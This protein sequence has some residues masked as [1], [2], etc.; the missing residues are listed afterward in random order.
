MVTR[1]HGNGE[2][3]VTTGRSY[4]ASDGLRI[5]PQERIVF[6][7]DL[8]C[9]G[10]FRCEADDP[11]FPHC[12]PPSVHTFVFPR[13]SVRIRHEGSRAFTA[14]PNTVTFYNRGQMYSRAKVSAEGDKCD[15]YTV[16]PSALRAIAAEVDPQAADTPEKPFR[17]SHGPSDNA[18]YLE[19]RRV[20]NHA[21]SS[22]HP[23]VLFVEET[24]LSVLS[25]V[26]EQTHTAHAGS[27]PGVRA[28]HKR[29]DDGAIEAVQ[30]RIARDFHR[31][32]SLSTLAEIAGLSVFHLC[33]L[34]RSEIGVTIHRYRHQLRLRQAL[35]TLTDSSTD[36]TELALDL[37]YSSHSHFTYVFRKTF[38][39]SPA[40]FRR[41]ASVR[42][43]RSLK[44]R[45]GW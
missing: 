23:D 36:L 30:L 24:I 32:L 7:S 2:P 41:E 19:Q 42:K 9:I 31:S 18:S 25:N 8:V 26:L 10:A 12:G 38:G 43:V 45:M 20:F 39:L 34:F 15:W 35:E 29:R 17:F 44:T 22:N 27:A 5:L 21:I 4:G 6:S 28:S 16:A 14:T 40:S 33:R 37:G 13:T 11:F 3:T 1:R